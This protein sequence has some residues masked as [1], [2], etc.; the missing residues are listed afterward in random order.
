MSILKKIFSRRYRIT[1]KKSRIRASIRERK[2]VT[3]R[4][5]KEQMA[6]QV[7]E[8][9]EVLPAFEKASTVLLYWSTPSELPTHEFVKKWAQSKT[10]LLPSVKGK[11]MFMKKFISVE[12]M[13]HGEQ[14]MR[15]PK[16]EKYTGK[17]D[18]VIIPGIAFDMKKNRMGRGRGYYDRFLSDLKV[19]AYGVCYDFQLLD[20][21]PTHSSDVRLDKVIAPHKLVE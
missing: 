19:E 6:I 1:L 17:V 7:W 18:L 3:P 21:V 15:E 4:E 9:L 14:K 11:K 20:K 5:E 13:E 16:T 12:E 8:Q 2:I 10:I